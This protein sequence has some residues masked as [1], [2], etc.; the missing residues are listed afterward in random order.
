M[1]CRIC[2]NSTFS[3]DPSKTSC[4]HCP[5]G[6]VCYGA[7]AFI[8]PEHSWHSGPN[9]T[10]IVLCP[11]ADACE[12]NR[13]VLLAC[14][15]VRLDSLALQSAYTGVCLQVTII[16][17]TVKIVTIII[18][19]IIIAGMA[20]KVF[21]MENAGVAQSIAILYLPRL[22]M[23]VS[24]ARSCYK[25]PSFCRLKPNLA[26]LRN[27]RGLGRNTRGARLYKEIIQRHDTASC[28]SLKF[29]G[30]GDVFILFLCLPVL[31]P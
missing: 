12:G 30:T 4:D 10:T 1:T 28:P 2:G 17:V 11:N 6:A 31:C 24:T 9:S 25:L 3:L 22:H 20:Q 26:L 21:L 7:D 13:T 8:P 29:H 23:T 5:S 14:K 19:T 27:T 18:V 15:Q 16:I